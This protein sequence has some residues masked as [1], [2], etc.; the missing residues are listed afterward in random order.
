[1]NSYGEDYL[2]SW[3]LLVYGWK[4]KYISEPLQCGLVP[5]TIEQWIT[6]RQRWL[7][8]LIEFPSILSND[9]KKNSHLN[10]IQKF[11]IKYSFVLPEY[12]TSLQTLISIIYSVL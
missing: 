5:W 12:L 2:T 11:L 10:I 1:M 6:Q 3:Y 7:R 8:S 4:S 9:I